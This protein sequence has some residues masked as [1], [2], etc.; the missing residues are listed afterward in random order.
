MEEEFESS[1]AGVD[2]EMVDKMLSK[3]Q[4]DEE[5]GDEEE[6]FEIEASKFSLDGSMTVS[7]GVD[8]YVPQEVQDILESEK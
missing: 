5:S 1:F 7:F 3:S 8:L 2:V 4:N 6:N